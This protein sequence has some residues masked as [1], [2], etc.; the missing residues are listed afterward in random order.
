MQM[1]IHAGKIVGRA[2]GA[3]SIEEE[4]AL[5]NRN[6]NLAASCSS[7]EE[8]LSQLLL[9]RRYDNM[10]YQGCSCYY[11]EIRYGGNTHGTS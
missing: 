8:Y 5:L 7:R 2:D 1:G 6:L 10:C 4:M 9:P 3:E 11:P